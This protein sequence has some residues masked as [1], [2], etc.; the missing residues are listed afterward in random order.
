MY[1]AK[2]ISQSVLADLAGISKARLSQILSDEANPTLK[3]FAGLFHALGERVCV[4]S[5]PLDVAVNQTQE[6]PAQGEWQWAQSI[7]MA[8]PISED[9]VA[10]MRR[11]TVVTE[12][13][14]AASNDN[15]APTTRVQFVESEVAGAIVSELETELAAA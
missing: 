12:K 15:Y 10:L 3:T 9:M 4:S 11:A 13:G 14:S 2:G 6:A 1:V 5:M 7:R 8:E